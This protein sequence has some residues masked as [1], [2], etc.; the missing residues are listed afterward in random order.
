MR[1][2]PVCKRQYNE[3]PA[4][5]RKDN[6]TEICPDCGMA[7]AFEAFG[8]S[9]MEAQKKVIEIIAATEKQIQ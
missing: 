9:E 2:C 4:L 3:H 8:L 7:E 5:S 6:L 1:V